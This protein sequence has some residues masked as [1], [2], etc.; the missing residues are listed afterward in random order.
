MPPGPV[1]DSNPGPPD[2]I[3]TCVYCG[4]AYPAGSPTHGASTLRDHIRVCK[5]HPLRDAE[6]KIKKLVEMLEYL[7]GKIE[8]YPISEDEIKDVAKEID[9]CIEENSA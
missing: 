8:E 4:K 2:R 7:K 1:S 6:A 3:V 5:K 9:E